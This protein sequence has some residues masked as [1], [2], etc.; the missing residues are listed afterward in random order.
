MNKKTLENKTNT[1]G[2]VHKN[3]PLDI[4]QVQYKYKHNYQCIEK[5]VEKKSLIT[6]RYKPLLVEQE[7]FI[8]YPEEDEGE[9]KFKTRTSVI[10]YVVDM[11]ENSYFI[12]SEEPKL[13][14]YLKQKL[15]D[16]QFDTSK[17]VLKN[18]SNIQNRKLMPLSS[19]NVEYSKISRS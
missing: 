6:H 1:L 16:N 11:D 7:Y 3:N 19:F 5:E 9:I 17:D 13:T 12:S 2:W 4:P 10:G 8:L 18:K 14:N 15:K